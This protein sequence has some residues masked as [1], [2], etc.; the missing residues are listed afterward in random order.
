MPDMI[1]LC[2]PLLLLVANGFSSKCI[3]AGELLGADTEQFQEET[4]Q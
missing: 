2:V 1:S 4:I 3:G